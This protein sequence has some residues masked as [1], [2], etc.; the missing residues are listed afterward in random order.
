MLWVGVDPGKSNK[1]QKELKSIAQNIDK[2]ITS[3]ATFVLGFLHLDDF[4][5]KSLVDLARSVL[6]KQFGKILWIFPVVHLDLSN[7][8]TFNADSF[9][10]LAFG[11]PE[12]VH[13]CHNN[14]N[15]ALRAV[16][17]KTSHVLKSYWD[18]HRDNLTEYSRNTT[19]VECSVQRFE[20]GHMRY[21]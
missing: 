6:G 5:L 16:L 10:A 13:C 8:Q 17:E 1:L 20:R 19:T 11:N 4:R 9:Q 14:Q 12:T 15:C 7:M 3:G 21:R 18:L 2:N